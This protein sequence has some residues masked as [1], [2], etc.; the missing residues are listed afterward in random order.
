MLTGTRTQ[1]GGLRLAADPQGRRD[2]GQHGGP[3][4]QRQQKPSVTGSTR[5][6]RTHV[7]EDARCAVWVRVTWAVLTYPPNIY[8]A[9]VMCHP[10]LI[11]GETATNQTA[12][13]LVLPQAPCAHSGWCSCNRA[14]H[15]GEYVLARG[16]RPSGAGQDL[17]DPE[18]AKHFG[19]GKLSPP[20]S[21]DDVRVVRTIPRT[22][23]VSP[24]PAPC[25]HGLCLKCH[26]P[27]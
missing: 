22:P 25:Q 20:Q 27:L 6:V 10:V 18:E 24:T 13:L 3:A 7:H 1:P 12:Q 8:L 2:S 11:I 9:H 14:G 16:P 5:R 26:P 21:Q 19:Q 17:G 23:T 4:S 15:V